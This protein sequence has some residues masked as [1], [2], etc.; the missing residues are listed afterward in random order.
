MLRSFVSLCEDSFDVDQYKLCGYNIREFDVPFI[1]RRLMVQEAEIP[2]L[3]KLR[4]NK[5]WEYPHIEL[6]DFWKFG[7]YKSY[8]PLGLLCKQLNIGYDSECSAH[9]IAVLYH[10][11]NK[12]Q[13]E[14]YAKNEIET[15]VNL[16]NRLGG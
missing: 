3:L 10:Q 7:D 1:S 4:S 12:V 13:I 16:F 5:P 11:E 15:I 9:D 2:S 14:A 6:L 8:V